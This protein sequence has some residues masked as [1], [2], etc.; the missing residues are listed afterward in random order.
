MI[1]LLLPACIQHGPFIW[2]S[3]EP[4][5]F[6]KQ[7]TEW[8]FPCVSPKIPAAITANPEFIWDKLQSSTF[9]FQNVLTFMCIYFL[10]TASSRLVKNKSNCF[11]I[12]IYGALPPLSF[13]GWAQQ[14]KFWFNSLERHKT[15]LPQA[16]GILSLT[17]HLQQRRT[18][19]SK[20]DVQIWCIWVNPRVAA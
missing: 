15:H 4:V 7:G 10:S 17:R 13:T 16:T 1:E 20:Y 8:S 18:L 11:L 19:E 3:D 5:G 12:W 2:A 6:L 14:N 9:F